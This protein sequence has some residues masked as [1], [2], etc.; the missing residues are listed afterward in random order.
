MELEQA[1]VGFCRALHAAG[2]SGGTEYRYSNLLRQWGRWIEQHDSSWS[3][4]TADQVEDFIEGYAQDHSKSS[5]SLMGTCLRSFYRW[6]ERRQHVASSPAARLAPAQRD[7]P[8]PRALPGWRVRQLLD[9][10]DAPPAEL[11]DDQADEWK[12]NRLIIRCYLFTGLRLAELAKLDKHDV[13]PVD[14]TLRVRGKGG[15]ERIVP[16]HPKIRDDLAGALAGAGPL[17]ESRRGG[18][19][20]A[21]GISDMFR[22]FVCGQLEVCCTAHQLRHSFATELRRQGADLREIQQLL[23]HAKLDTTAI[24]TQVYPDD[25]TGAVQRLRW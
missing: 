20:S 8:L 4:A 25:L 11:D 9:R 21:A 14:G 13:D 6:A 15:K 17:F 19:L 22:K 1:I 2:R 18:P 24:Y 5:T 3:R 7:R 16:I 12:R 10:L 23:G